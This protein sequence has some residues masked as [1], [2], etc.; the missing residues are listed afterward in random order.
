VHDQQSWED[1]S[2]LF[3]MQTG[4]LPM[5]GK[6]MQYTPELKKMLHDS[7]TNELET[8]KIAESKA[9]VRASDA[10]VRVRNSEVP[11]N[12]AREKL[13][14]A[15]AGAVTKA[16]AQAKLPSPAE[17]KEVTDLIQ[18]D[19]ATE[20]PS[21][22][23]GRQSFDASARAAAAPIV[24]QAR[25]YAAQGMPRSQANRRA[26]AEAKAKG[27][28]DKV[29][30]SGLVTG[31]P[32]DKA[33]TLIDDL[34]KITEDSKKRTLGVTGF[35]GRLARGVETAENILGPKVVGA[36]NAKDHIAHDFESK[37]DELQLLLPKLLTGTSRSA[38]DERDKVATIARGLKLGDTPENTIS[39]LNALKESLIGN[40]QKPTVLKDGP[41]TVGEKPPA[42]K[43]EKNKVYT[44]PKGQRAR[45]L[46]D[47]QWQTL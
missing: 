36:K 39:A 26:V 41:G 34:N 33:V 13:E 29:Q 18:S 22:L 19:P 17:I 4:H 46:G 38:K 23:P 10:E 9:H 16:G 35:A 24:E 2:N 3:A 28:L 42:D 43:F 8:A 44:N 25:I 20:R 7:V 37:S 6:K 11:L 21:D 45:Y 1:A 5:G 14:D 30:S 40:R 15:R 47:G 31:S 27:D 12:K 32:L